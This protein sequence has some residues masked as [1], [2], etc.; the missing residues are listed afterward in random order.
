ML[1]QVNSHVIDLGFKIYQFF[2]TFILISYAVRC[3]NFF[4]VVYEIDKNVGKDIV[5][6]C[7]SDSF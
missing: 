6:W 3:G 4:W 2:R 5:L 1:L 7:S